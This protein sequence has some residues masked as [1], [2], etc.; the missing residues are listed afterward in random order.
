MKEMYKLPI[1]LVLL[2]YANSEYFII[3]IG[4][5]HTKVDY[6]LNQAKIMCLLTEY[7]YST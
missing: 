2:L 7:C 4:D 3:I 1:L 5:N 6:N